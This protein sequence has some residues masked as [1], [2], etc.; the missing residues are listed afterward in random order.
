[1]I[2]TTSSLLLA[3]LLLTVTTPSLSQAKN[4]SRMAMPEQMSVGAFYGGPVGASA[5][6]ILSED[7]V[8][9]AAVAMELGGNQNILSWADYLWRTNN[10]FDVMDYAIGYYF[11][12]GVKFRTENDPNVEAEY[13]AGPRAVAGLVHEMSS[14]SIEIFGE[15]AFTKHVMGGDKTEMDLALGVRY[16]F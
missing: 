16:Y 6:Y 1:M 13:M 14:L 12:G 5:T 7:N 10:A 2:K 4:T 15:G 3:C 11:G 9:D 8:I